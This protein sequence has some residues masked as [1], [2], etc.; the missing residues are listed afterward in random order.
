M[1]SILNLQKLQTN[2]DFISETVKSCSSSG[3]VCC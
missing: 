2:D 3:A 1:S